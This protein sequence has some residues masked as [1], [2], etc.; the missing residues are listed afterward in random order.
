MSLKE[1]AEI[2]DHLATTIGILMGG[3]WVLYQYMIRRAGETG[4]SIDLLST[5]SARPDGRRLLFLD[6]VFKNTGNARLDASVVSG[7]SLAEQFEGSVRFAGSL[8]LR[9]IEAPSLQAATHVDWWG[10]EPGLLTSALP[11][12]NLLTEYT[13]ASGVAEFF[14]EPGEEYHLGTAFVVDPGAYL[15]K[16]VFVGQREAEYW[17]RIVHVR[18]E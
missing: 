15:A 4:L 14:M 9:K 18:V 3:G 1:L 12:V 17:S 16:A 6:V 10:K 2:A 7:D 11:E 5:V 8:Q 13:D